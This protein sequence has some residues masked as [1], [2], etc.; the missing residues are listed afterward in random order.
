MILKK[1]IINGEVYYK[2]VSGDESKKLDNDSVVVVGDEKSIK[3][4]EENNILKMLPYLKKEYVDDVVEKY[5]GTIEKYGDLKLESF[6]PYLSQNKCDEYF[7]KYVINKGYKGDLTKL[8]PFVSQECLSSLVNSYI[9]EDKYSNIDWDS[10]YPY[11][12]AADV[13]RLFIGMIEKEKER[14]RE[15]KVRKYEQ[16]RIMRQQMEQMMK[17][18]QM[19]E[20]LYQ[21]KHEENEKLYQQQLE[22][23]EKLLQ[24]QIDKTIE[25]EKKMREE[26]IKDEEENM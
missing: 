22:E 15:E 1:V 9:N 4:N 8:I 26:I 11:I 3:E 12:G 14:K 19:N 10:I 17:D 16:L 6:F 25:I 24:Q 21:Q 13:K 18:K 23:R 5:I 2:E 20:K 7:I